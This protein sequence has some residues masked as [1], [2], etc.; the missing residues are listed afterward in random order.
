MILGRVVGNVVAT[1]KNK[2]LFGKKLMIVQPIDCQGNNAGNEILAVDG[3]GAGVGELVLAIG[4]GGS[5]RIVTRTENLAPID[6]A[7]AGIVDSISCS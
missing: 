2:H 6:M 7:I 5:A 4:E 1:Q 3:I